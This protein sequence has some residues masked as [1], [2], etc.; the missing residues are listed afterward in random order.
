MDWTTVL[1]TRLS[2]CACTKVADISYPLHSMCILYSYSCLKDE[3]THGMG[4]DRHSNIRDF[5]NLRIFPNR[6][7][8]QNGNLLLSWDCSF[9][10]APMMLKITM[11]FV[12]M[13][14]IIKI[15]VHATYKWV[16]CCFLGFSSLEMYAKNFKT[17]LSGGRLV[18]GYLKVRSYL[19]FSAPHQF[20]DGCINQLKS[21]NHL[22][23]LKPKLCCITVTPSL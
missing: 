16:L 4:L 5:L 11:G 17:I 14:I 6:I 12:H 3:L 22:P 8:A 20:S 9:I 2:A 23:W 7:L 1:F 21:K 18:E 13:L 15:S 10:W 19:W